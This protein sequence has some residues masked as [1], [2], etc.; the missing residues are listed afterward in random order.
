M[1]ERFPIN[2]SEMIRKIEQEDEKWSTKFHE[3][4]IKQTQKQGADI[5]G[6]GEYVRAKQSKFWNEQV[7]TKEKWQEMYKDI[8]V[9]VNVDVRI[10]RVG[11]K[12]I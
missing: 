1:N 6:F 7:K 9:D 3:G 2:T 8:S 5:F 4:L 12:A 10:R 11:M